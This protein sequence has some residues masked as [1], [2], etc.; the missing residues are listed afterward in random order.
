ML[1]QQLA[2]N[3][4]SLFEYVKEHPDQLAAALNEGL[5]EEDEEPEEI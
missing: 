5:E 2:T 4:P 1:I 3:N